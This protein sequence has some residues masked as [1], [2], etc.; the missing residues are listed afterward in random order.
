MLCADLSKCAFG[1]CRGLEGALSRARAGVAMSS[2]DGPSGMQD[3]QTSRHAEP[4]TRRRPDFSRIASVGPA[5]L[6][7][8]EPAPMEALLEPE[9]TNALAVPAKSFIGPNATYYD[10]RWRWMHWRG[11]TRSWNWAAASTFGAW[12]AYRRMAGAA[13][14]HGGWLCLLVALA[15]SGVPVGLLVLAQ[16]VVALGL[17][18]YGNTLYFH[19]YMRVAEKLSEENQEHE[20][21]N[22][23]AA[24]SGGVNHVAVWRYASGVLGLVLLLVLAL[25]TSGAIRLGF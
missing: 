5:G 15:L 6:A 23:A 4:E 8:P 9:G 17:G 2:H 20:T 25:R 19:H 24:S 12:L 11:R 16:L 1:L 14:A 10:D 13:L 18:L 7:M 21:L 22:A 3:Y